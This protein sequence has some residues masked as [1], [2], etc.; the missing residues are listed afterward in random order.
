VTVI[1]LNPYYILRKLWF[2]RTCWCSSHASL[3]SRSWLSTDLALA[4]LA[5]ELLKQRQ[6][7]QSL[8]ELY[9]RLL[10]CN[11][12][13]QER[14]CWSPQYESSQRHTRAREIRVERT[15]AAAEAAAAAGDCTLHT[16]NHGTHVSPSRTALEER[17]CLGQT[18]LLARPKLL[19]K[20]AYTA[21]SGVMS[22]SGYMHFL[23]LMHSVLLESAVLQVK[24]TWS[25]SIP[26]Q[27]VT[28][29]LL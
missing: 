20:G 17:V 11:S 6:P 10:L 23:A 26:V 4:S 2:R 22:P 9:S 8:S 16:E 1:P 5:S 13:C 12:E 15:F 3:P 14:S 29:R 7:S 24:L 25:A 19:S 28:A 18:F 21:A 27:L